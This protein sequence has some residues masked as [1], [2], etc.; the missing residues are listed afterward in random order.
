MFI[1][2][3][4]TDLIFDAQSMFRASHTG[5]SRATKYRKHNAKEQRHRSV[6]DY[7]KIHSFF[8]RTN[9]PQLLV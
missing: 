9:P 8:K 2:V 4:S 3:V 7:P 5:D 1:A 6:D